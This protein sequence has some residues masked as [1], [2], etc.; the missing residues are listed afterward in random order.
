LPQHTKLVD[1]G[2]WTDRCFAT[3]WH[4]ASPQNNRSNISGEYSMLSIFRH[5]MKSE[6]GATPIE[7]M[8]ISSLIAVAAIVAM[9]SVR[10]KIQNVLSNVSHAMG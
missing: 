5:L 3:A 8:L 6:H 4:A 2:R 7:Y 1:L 9:R 10:G